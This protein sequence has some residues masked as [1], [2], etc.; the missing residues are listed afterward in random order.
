MSPKG[1]CLGAAVLDKTMHKSTFFF[2][3]VGGD[4]NEKGAIM[5]GSVNNPGPAFNDGED[6][7]FS[8]TMLAIGMMLA[9]VVA[10][11]G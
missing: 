6:G 5:V 1:C 7:V 4:T 10:T 2:C 8:T 9:C 11:C 3:V